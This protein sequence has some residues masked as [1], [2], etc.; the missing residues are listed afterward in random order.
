MSH[1]TTPWLVGTY[2]IKL[3]STGALEQPAVFNTLGVKMGCTCIL[4]M[5]QRSPPVNM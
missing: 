1:P 2:L 5:G 3:G 4:V